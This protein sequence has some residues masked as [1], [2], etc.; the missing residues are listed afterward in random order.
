M[1][2]HPKASVGRPVDRRTAI[3]WV[4]T[5]SAALASPWSPSLAASP[6]PIA[7]LPERPGYGTDP[8]LVR[9]YQAGDYWPLTLGAAEQASVTVLAD[10]ILPADEASPAASAIGVPAFIDEWISAPYPAHRRDRVTVLEGLQWLDQAAGR[11]GAARFVNLSP[12]R[13]R[14]ICDAIAGTAVLPEYAAPARFFATFRQLCLGA[15]YT[16]PEG[17]RAIG[18]VGNLP[19]AE[20][21]GPPQVVLER[22]GIDGHVPM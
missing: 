8:D 1:N 22:L 15:Y 13:Q 14:E 7:P 12:D 3:K 4:L 5:A 11:R 17:M 6:S 16:T 10:L 20:F 18:Y 9:A 2:V 19:S 21:L